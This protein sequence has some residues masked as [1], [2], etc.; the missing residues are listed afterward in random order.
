MDPEKTASFELGQGGDACLLIHGFTGSP[1]DMR[2]L[3][4][5]LAARG[6]HVLG[7]RLPGHGSTPEAMEQV[8][9]RDWL[10]AA[11]Q[12][13]SSLGSAGRIF[14]G[15][16]SMGALLALLLAAKY[17]E[18]LTALAMIAPALRLRGTL[19]EALR[20]TR[21]IPVLDLL[22]PF[23]EKRSTDIEDPVAREDAPL[24]AG[25]PSARLH[26]LWILQDKVRETMASV[27]TP[28]LIATAKNDHVASRD[29]A[30]ELVRG[31][32]SSR[33]VEWLELEEGFHII[34]RD[35]SAARLGEA[36]ARFFDGERSAASSQ[37]AP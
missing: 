11:D 35:R 21:N 32:R 23:I 31:L 19:M 10:D 8:T 18:R 15:G 3:G 17:P 24:L 22:R 9:Y 33:R 36:V 14:V 13:L 4:E 16:L 12:A 25:F 28:A 26:D 1:W 29:G 5:A 30:Q 2:P 34:P 37:G 7:I 20:W 27:R 6:Y